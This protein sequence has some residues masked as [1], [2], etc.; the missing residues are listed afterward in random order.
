MESSH[1]FNSYSLLI[2]SLL[3]ALFFSCI[4][5]QCSDDPKVYIVYMGAADEH[6]SHLLSSHHAQMLASVS[7]S[8][9]SAME[10]IV[11]S[12]TRAINGFAAKMLPS[13]ASMLQQMPGVVSVFEDYTVSLQTTRS[14][15]FIGLEDASGNTAANSLWKKTMGENMIIGVL[16]SGVWPES[17]SFSDAGLP[18]SLPAKWHGSCASS[19][20]FTC[21]RK[22]IGARY[23]GFSGGRPLNPRDETG[24]GSHVSSI[25]AGARVPGVDDLGLARGTAKGVAPQARIAVYKIC[26][27]VK[28]AGADVLKGWDDA[29]GDGVD[30]INY[31]VGSSNSPYWS[32]VASIGGFHAVRKGVV[33]VAAAANGGIGCVVQNTA[34]WVT[35]VAAST[36]DRR[37]PS[38]VVLGDGSLY[39]GSSINNFSLGNSFYPLVNGRDIPAPTTS[40]ESAMGCSPGALDPAKAQGKIV[41]CGP[42]SVDFKDI[43]DG[44]KAIGAVGFIM[45]NDADGKE[46]LLSLRFTMPATEV[47]NTAANSISSYIKSSRNPTAKII[48][49][50]TVINQK[51][52]PMMGIFSCKGPNPVVSDILKPD[53]TAPGVDILAA[54][55]EAADKPPLKYKFAS[56]TSMA[57]PHVAGLST[58]LKSLH[59]DWSP[60]AIKSAIMTTAYTQD[61]TGKTIL[62]GD[63]DVAGPFNYG[64][65]HINPVA[66]ADPG[67]V[68]DAGKQDYVAF[69]CNIG[70]SAGQIQA[71]TGEPGNCPATRG[72]GSDLNYPSVTLTNLARGAAVTR[73]LTSVSDSPSTYSIGITPPSGISVTANPTSLTFSKKGEQ[74]TFTLNFVV[75]YDFLPR[76]YVY[77]EYVW[78]DNTHTVR[79][80]IVVNAVS[81]LAI[82][83]EKLVSEI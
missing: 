18:A 83:E 79:S 29:I 50:T 57:S 23:Y 12:Y 20:S 61:N 1:S 52:S 22:V 19:A 74:K 58:L 72:R 43:A 75:N 13:Q 62:D 80:P 46:R 14:I 70:F 63:Y 47:G 30:V 9:E 40:P 39:Q 33:V 31:S 11:H 73:T 76:Q 15:N 25:A 78:Y 56:G 24:H 82:G 59:S 37:F 41:L 16:D 27:A 26:W 53:V 44:L 68:Y 54:W 81:R 3:L 69:L 48:P 7:N 4:A 6:H 67:L 66:A 28:C 77:G 8:V 32:D 21:N 35:T 65:G 36:I 55:S 71:M 42:P 45:G 5:T 34:P 51:P 2:S 10:T 49:P 17:A 60:A 38:N 64:S